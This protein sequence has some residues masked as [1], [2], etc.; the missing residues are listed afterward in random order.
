M[1][2]SG[3]FHM[4]E[5]LLTRSNPASFEAGLFRGWDA[6]KMAL[7]RASIQGRQLLSL[8]LANDVRMAKTAEKESEIEETEINAALGGDQE[9]FARL[10]RM[11]QATIAKHLWRF[12]G[13]AQ[14]HEELVHGTFVE[15]YFSL[16][17][18]RQQGRFVYWLKTIATRLAYRYWKEKQKQRQQQELTAPDV[19]NHEFKNWAKLDAAQMSSSEAADILHKLLEQLPPR[20]RL[21]LTLL[22]WDDC[23]VAEAA[24]LAGWSQTMVKVQAHRARK[25]LKKLLEQSK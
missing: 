22:Y 14:A 4:L 25:K 5:G 12:T 6:V 8:A 3:S 23:S 1:S 21:V 10:V 18:Y 7:R 24:E 9:A 2:S 16:N 19:Q 20:D 15:A 13:D 11:H 17:T